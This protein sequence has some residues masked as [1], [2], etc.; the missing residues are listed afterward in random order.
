MRTMYD[1]TRA[2][3][4]PANATMVAGYVDE[5]TIPKWSAAEWAR[6]PNAT[7]VRIAKRAATNDGH[8]LDVEDKL[9]RPDEAPGWA[10]TRRRSGLLTPTIYCNRS[11]WDDVQEEFERQKVAPPLYFIATAN[12]KREI[13]AG[14]IAAQYQLDT[15]N[16]DVSCVADYWPGVDPAPIGN[17]IAPPQE[18][19]VSHILKPGTNL[20]QV[21][22]VNGRRK[23]YIGH[24]FPNDHAPELQRTVKVHQIVFFGD[25]P[26]QGGEVAYLPSKYDLGPGDPMRVAITIDPGRPG[27]LEV[28]EGCTAGAAR[29]STDMDDAL[30]WTA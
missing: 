16:V 30:L 3:N 13:P 2:K 25:T 12:G 10:L 14:A 9:A 17:T 6:F 7:K 5:Y 19:D 23:L 26:A 21:F 27:P 18:D 15:N 29:Y 22:E 28:P 4:I 24:A 1:S 11:T 20:T 8:V